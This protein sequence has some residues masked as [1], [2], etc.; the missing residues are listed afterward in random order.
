MVLCVGAVPKN[1][2]ALG[3]VTLWLF[4]IGVSNND[5]HNQHQCLQLN[6]GHFLIFRYSFSMV[7]AGFSCTAA[8]VVDNVVLVDD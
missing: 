7:S 4:F 8:V 5:C 2:W 1:C 6:F 3:E